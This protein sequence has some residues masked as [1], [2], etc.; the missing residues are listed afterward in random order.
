MSEALK[1]KKPFLKK[2]TR[3]F[4]SNASV[5]SK[6]TKIQIVDFGAADEQEQ[7][8]DIPVQPKAKKPVHN[9]VEIKVDI[10]TNNKQNIPPRKP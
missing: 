6:N 10:K 9:D 2:G 4:L 1:E 7:Y 8:L 3:Q 5:R